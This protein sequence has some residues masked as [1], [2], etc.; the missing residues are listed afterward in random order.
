VGTESGLVL[1]QE[2]KLS[3]MFCNRLRIVQTVE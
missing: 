1:G 3:A 2:K